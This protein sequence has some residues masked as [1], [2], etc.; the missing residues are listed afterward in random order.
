MWFE[1]ERKKIKSNY[2]S[3]L[4][5]I[6]CLEETICCFDFFFLNP[7]VP[8]NPPTRRDYYNSL[9][10]LHAHGRMMEVRARANCPNEIVQ[11]IEIDLLQQQ[12]QPTTTRSASPSKNDFKQKKFQ[13]RS[14]QS[15]SEGA[16]CFPADMKGP[17]GLFR[18]V[19]REIREMGRVTI[20]MLKGQ[21]S[22][23]SYLFIPALISLLWLVVCFMTT[24]NTSMSLEQR[25]SQSFYKVS[26]YSFH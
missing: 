23:L 2:P 13:R 25:L 6:E 17:D 3:F 1:K 5:F 8:Q 9:A 10:K 12:Q 20:Q 18:R 22:A 26:H 14:S 16:S 7:R 21:G 11:E 15:K 4:S 19:R 24:R